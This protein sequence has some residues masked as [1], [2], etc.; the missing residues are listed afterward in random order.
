MKAFGSMKAW[1]K[2]RRALPALLVLYSVL[3]AVA[4]LA[5]TSGDQSAMASWVSDLGV[6]VGF[7]PETANQARA[8]FL[9]NIAILAPVS[10]LGSL[11]WPRTTWRDWTAY[12]FVI[13][14]SVELA[15]GIVLSARTASSADVVANTLGGLVGAVVVLAGRRLVE[16]RAGSG[17]SG[18]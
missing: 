12:T 13:A 10:A 6:W 3:L 18:S 17:P 14:C 2:I 4:L 15:Q 11:I 8:E 5:P 1:G 9:C 16:R 7:A